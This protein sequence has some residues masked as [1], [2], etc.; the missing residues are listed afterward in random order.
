MDMSMLNISSDQVVRHNHNML[1]P[2]LLFSL[3]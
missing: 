3:D 2:L 1:L